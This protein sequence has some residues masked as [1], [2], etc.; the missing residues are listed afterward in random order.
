MICDYFSH[1]IIPFTCP[2]QLRPIV[3]M[4]FDIEMVSSNNLTKL[5]WVFVNEGNWELDSVSNT[6]VYIQV[7]YNERIRSKE[8]Y[9]ANWNIHV[10]LIKT[11]NAG[12]TLINLSIV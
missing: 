7:I 12:I 3:I 6:P 10:Q 4:L 1:A 8:M 2:K 9:F 5:C 11:R